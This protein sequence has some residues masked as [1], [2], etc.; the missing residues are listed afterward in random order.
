MPEV[1]DDKGID[2]GSVNAGSAEVAPV[3]APT[4]EP[5]PMAAPT[6]V[7]EPTP[8]AAPATPAAPEEGTLDWHVVENNR[9]R[10][11]INEG[12]GA[13][14][15]APVAQPTAPVQPAQQFQSPQ[16]AP[17]QWADV[18]FLGNEPLDKLLDTREG[19]NA[20]LNAVARKA[21][22]LATVRASEKALMGM[23]EVVT[24][25]VTNMATQ[26]AMHDEFYKVNSDLVP[27]K[28]VCAGLANKLA[29]EHSDWSVAQVFETSANEARKTLGLIRAAAPGA[30]NQGPAFAG[31]TPARSGPGASLK[32]L[33][34]EIAD[35]IQ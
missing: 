18:D 3:V 33:E 24:K 1:K 30:A 28:R 34:K 19:L 7:A 2:M 20:M 14:A 5:V 8:T 23:P 16:P 29:S 15:P 9:L 32:G 6:P 10:A 12:F 27:Y 25:Y 11:L 22:D 17:E 31:G 13:T 21:F 26:R 35:L 4:P